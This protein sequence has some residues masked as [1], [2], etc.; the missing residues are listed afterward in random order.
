MKLKLCLVNL[1]GVMSIAL[2]QEKLERIK[3][4][5]LIGLV[6]PKAVGGKEGL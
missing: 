3:R 4:R 1:N 5:R 2:S 6:I